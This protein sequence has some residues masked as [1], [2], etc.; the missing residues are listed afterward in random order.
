MEGEPAVHEAFTELAQS[1]EQAMDR[2][3][4]GLLSANY[5]QFIDRLLGFAPVTAHDRVLDL[6]T[7][8]ARI[9]RELVDRAKAT[10]GIVGLD[11]TP[12]MLAQARAT[13]STARY[14]GVIHLVC[15]SGTAVACAAGTFD[16]VLCG[17]GTHHMDLQ[18][19]LSEVRRVLKD[20]GSLVLAEAGAPRFWRA[21]WGRAFLWLSLRLYRVFSGGARARAETEAVLNMRTGEE[22]RAA[23]SGAGFTS[24]EIHDQPA[25][26]AWYPR[27]LV[28]RAVAGRA[29]PG[30]VHA[31]AQGGWNNI[32]AS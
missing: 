4:L 25:R 7:G 8:T 21:W 18:D 17:F 13:C 22:W 20:G 6:A 31:R 16:V 11:I 5:A 28:I 32:V 30:E 10:G 14:A 26:R 9:P 23:L 12:A 1:Y 15:A 3:L 24:I 27:V 29:E 19:M 2:E